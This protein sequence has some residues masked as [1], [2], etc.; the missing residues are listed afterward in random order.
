MPV[1]WFTFGNMVSPN[2][3][4]LSRWR[5]CRFNSLTLTVATV[6]DICGRSFHV[7]RA[8]RVQWIYTANYR[9]S[10]KMNM[11]VKVMVCGGWKGRFLCRGHR[12]FVGDVECCA[13]YDRRYLLVPSLWTHGA[14][15]KITLVALQKDTKFTWL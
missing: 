14:R 2:P 8:V 1:F 3:V 9:Q 7:V 4:L 12:R 6:R 11:R 13:Q 5:D 10:F 15:W